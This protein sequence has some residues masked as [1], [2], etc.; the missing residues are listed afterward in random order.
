MIYSNTLEK[1][2]SKLSSVTIQAVKFMRELSQPDVCVTREKLVTLEECAEWRLLAPCPLKWF[3]FKTSYHESREPAFVACGGNL[4]V[5]PFRRTSTD[6]RVCVT[7][8]RNWLSVMLSN[9]CH[10]H[11]SELCR[12]CGKRFASDHPWLELNKL[13]SRAANHARRALPSNADL[14]RF[15]QHDWKLAKGD[16]AWQLLPPVTTYVSVVLSGHLAR[17]RSSTLLAWFRGRG[18]LRLRKWGSQQLTPRTC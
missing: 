9:C 18:R 3:L 17:R 6:P 1:T 14:L 15:L 10:P 5:E 8:E 7:C 4:G 16:D 2:S 12:R 11:R 13:R